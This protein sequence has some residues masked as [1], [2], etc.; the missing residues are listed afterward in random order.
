MRLLLAGVFLTVVTF[1]A[2]GAGPWYYC[3]PLGGYYPFVGKCPVPWHE[4]EPRDGAYGPT[5]APSPDPNEAASP[6]ARWAPA[7]PEVSRD[8]TTAPPQGDGEV[9]ASFLQGQADRQGWEAWL[10]GLRGD[11]RAGAEY[12]AAYRGAQ[13]ARPCST[14]PTSTDYDWTTGCFEARQRLTSFDERRQT[15]S[16][17]RLGWDNPPSFEASASTRETTETPVA[18][19]PDREPLSLGEATDAPV[20][21][22]APPP[23]PLPN[24]VTEAPVV[25][26]PVQAPPA[27]RE[28]AEAPI[29]AP[30]P[31]S[32]DVAEVP[33][34]QIPGRIPPAASD[35]AESPA[36]EAPARAPAHDIG[37]SR[38]ERG[39][40]G[41]RTQEVTPEIAES[42]DLPK[43][44]GALI[45]SVAPNSPAKRN[46]IK[47]GDVIT[48]YRGHSIPRTRDLDLAVAATP[49]GQ[50]VKIRLWRDGHGLTV[51]PM[52]LA[53]AGSP[54]PQSRDMA[55]G[56][57]L[58]HAVPQ[59]SAGAAGQRSKMVPGS[60]GGGAFIDQW[61]GD[62]T[63]TTHPFH[64]DGPWE[65]QWA[66]AS[67]PFVIELAKPGGRSDVIANQTDQA[68]SSS[69][70]PEG[71][72]YYLKVIANSP[73]SIKLV[74]VP[75]VAAA[76]RNIGAAVDGNGK[77]LDGEY[78]ALH[79]HNPAAEPQMAALNASP[80]R[81][82]HENGEEDAVIRTIR[83]A[84]EQYRSGKNPSQQ[85]AVRPMRAR[86]LCKILPSHYVR[87]WVGTVQT[88]TR[89]EKGRGVL[90]VEIAPG[91]L[92]RTWNNTLADSADHTL[93]DPNSQVF[94]SLSGLR[95][96]QTIL[97]S[98][99][100]PASDTDCIEE[101][102]LTA[103]D[104]LT[105]PQF[106]MNFQSVAPLD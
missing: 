76:D 78:R 53:M 14:A 12:W 19:A 18:Q 34:A 1:P 13:G 47:P 10:R 40:L 7:L 9:S 15:D 39:W 28:A 23:P 2:A 103:H 82:A 61:S 87:N 72:D 44:A 101:S 29:A 94:G 77:T 105:D 100:F 79:G 4:V 33:I 69:F 54:E 68:S 30:D 62:G 49:P 85:G 42:L 59:A 60:H 26:A 51:T 57:A 96:G 89:T 71:G 50:A 80:M 11:Y 48:A 67:G 31:Y 55:A 81:H 16:Q 102:G 84:M 43:A 95:A 45:V 6:P 36:A 73:W 41:V 27:A 64:A 35:L 46:G 65:I 92:V 66:T 22:P 38:V 98:G 83:A 20:A 86:G 106:I 37:P 70:V 63:L 58:R 56:R 3:D 17:Y 88:A 24:Q 97:F 8:I 25:Q 74:S 21:Q 93:I 5:G 104:S 90:S 75:P 52:I 32:R 91:I 99:T